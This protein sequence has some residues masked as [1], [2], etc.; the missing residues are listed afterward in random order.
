MFL[1]LVYAATTWYRYG[2][3]ARGGKRDPLLDRFIP[4]YEV[5]ERHEIRV[6]APAMITY[7]AAREMDLHHSQLV[8]AIFRGRELLMRAQPT[9]ER[10]PQ[11]LLDEVLALGWGVLAEEPG[12]EI[13]VGTVTQ[14]WEANVS[15][16]SLPPAEFAAFQKPGHAKIVWTLA[17]KPL[18]PAESVFCTET[19]VA[20]TDRYARERFRRYW[21]VFSP[22]ILLIRRQSLRLVRADAE[23]RHRAEAQRHQAEPLNP[24]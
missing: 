11:P 2:R 20:T 4:S 9:G 17:V 16:H 21:A 15:F 3:E 6:A 10:R 7:A 13:V 23:R 18:G 22:G 5:A 14:P 1:W 8:R 19:R 12:L 24:E